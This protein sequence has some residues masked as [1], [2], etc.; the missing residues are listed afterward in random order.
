MKQLV[1][2]QTNNLLGK[3]R[4]MIHSTCDLVLRTGTER[5]HNT[6]LLK[7]RVHYSWCIIIVIIRYEKS[8]KGATALT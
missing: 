2:Q 4:I 7:E 1:C 5:S 3:N 8:F 6:F